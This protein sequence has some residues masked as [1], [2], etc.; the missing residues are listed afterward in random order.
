MFKLKVTIFDARLLQL[1]SAIHFHINLGFPQQLFSA[2][3]L[4]G[5][6]SQFV[7]QEI[8]QRLLVIVSFLVTT[9]KSI[10]MGTLGY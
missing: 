7:L 4:L 5:F 1:S 10:E 3:S 2:Q 8:F 9:C 6:I